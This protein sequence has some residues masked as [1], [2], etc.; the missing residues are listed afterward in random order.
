MVGLSPSVDRSFIPSGDFELFIRDQGLQ[1]ATVVSTTMQS[2]QK[3][4]RLR[5]VDEL[6]QSDDPSESTEG[7]QDLFGQSAC[8]ECL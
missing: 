4:L 7:R 6:K 8:A 1:G 3:A 2:G 5:L